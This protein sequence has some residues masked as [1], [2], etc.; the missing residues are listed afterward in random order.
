MKQWKRLTSVLLVLG[1][2]L[3]LMPLSAFAAEP[4]NAV[5]KTFTVTEKVTGGENTYTYRL[6]DDNTVE[7][8]EFST[9]ASA[10][11]AVIP[12]TVPSTGNKYSVVSIGKGAFF[13]CTA[14][15]SVQ[16]EAPIK[17]IGFMAFALC[18]GLTSIA[19]PEGL[20]TIG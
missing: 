12:S 17:S 13:E 5:A 9:T 8:K 19:L 3:G 20:E 10:A 11:N 7:L 2:V 14:L 4:E 16:F 1:M 15:Q 18:T 6:L